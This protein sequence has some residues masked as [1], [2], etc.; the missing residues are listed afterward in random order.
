MSLS[1][2]SQRRTRSASST[3][4]SLLTPQFVVQNMD[5]FAILGYAAGY[6]EC[7]KVGGFCPGID[8]M[9]E[10]MA[11]YCCQ[12]GKKIEGE[13]IA[14]LARTLA[15]Q[16]TATGTC[17][18]VSALTGFVGRVYPSLAGS[19]LLGIPPP[20]LEE[21]AQRD[22]AF[23]RA[24]MASKQR[25]VSGKGRLPVSGK[26]RRP[27]SGKGRRAVTLGGGPEVGPDGG[28]FDNALRVIEQ[29]P[30]MQDV[31]QTKLNSHAFLGFMGACLDCAQHGGYCPMM[32]LLV[33]SA[34]K[35]CV[36]A[37]HKLTEA[38]THGLRTVL[39]GTMHAMQS[40]GG[41]S[42]LPTCLTAFGGVVAGVVITVYDR[43]YCTACHRRGVRDLRRASVVVRKAYKAPRTTLHRLQAASYLT[44][45]AIAPAPLAP[46][47]QHLPP[48]QQVPRHHRPPH[49]QQQIPHHQQLPGRRAGRLRCAGARAIPAHPWADRRQDRRTPRPQ[50]RPQLI[51]GAS[52]SAYQ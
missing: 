28:V 20:E 36:Y 17:G 33:Y 45:S 5:P 34:I 30:G 37:P 39:M 6:A 47:H 18:S 23:M 43:R 32:E 10:G 49:P 21:Q 27:V 3:S 51:S 8:V 42:L 15:T 41:T 14:R 26:G 50:V 7:Y 22:Q 16:H 1:S 2:T 31:F 4:G 35:H 46:L 40:G 24:L 38:E 9:A 25:P 48:Q 52:M 29:V 19:L 44:A 13:D 11:T 12:L